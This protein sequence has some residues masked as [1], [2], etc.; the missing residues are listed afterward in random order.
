MEINFIC[1][2]DNTS[3]AKFLFASESVT[4]VLG[5]LPEELIGKG[6]YEFTHPLERKALAT[7]HTANVQNERMSSITTYRSRH[8]D[9]HYINCDVVVHY[10]YDTLVCTNFAIVSSDCIKH[11]MRSSSV[12]A[13]FVIQE[14]GSIRLTG[15]WNDSQEKMKSLLTSEYPWDVHHKVISQQEPRF[16]LFLNRYTQKSN[17]VFATK[18]CESMV[19]LSQ[20]ECI[21]HPLYDYIDDKDIE[22]VMHQIEL[23][24]SQALIVRV[25]FLWKKGQ[26]ECIP[27]EAVVSCTYDGLVFV[28]RLM[29]TL[30]SSS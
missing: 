10:C 11:Q 19:G 9:G 16:C 3:E 5:Y 25:R 13:S 29:P 8:K 18:M 26:G 14:D 22:N 23:S 21:G 27:I 15:A 30:I 20:L 7:I 12:D 2:Y 6:G 4:D 28:A 24:K 17:I 1:I